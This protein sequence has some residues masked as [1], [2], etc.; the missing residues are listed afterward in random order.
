[1]GVIVA[2][3]V[4]D[5]ERVAVFV[6]VWLGQG[7]MVGVFVGGMPGVANGVRVG[8]SLG[9]ERLAFVGDRSGLTTV[10]LATD[11]SILGVGP[12]AV[13]LGGSTA[14]GNLQ[15]ATVHSRRKL[16]NKRN[17][18]VSSPFYWSLSAQFGQDDNLI[19]SSQA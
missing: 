5:G 2:V 6:G 17:L 9:P 18:R 14:A 11:S 3:G 4:G 1:M 8:A 10:L 19:I 12:G 16:R 7:E 13:P 15:A